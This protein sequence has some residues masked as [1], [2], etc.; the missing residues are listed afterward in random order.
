MLASDF[1]EMLNDKTKL[2]EDKSKEEYETEIDLD[3]NSFLVVEKSEDNV[4]ELDKRNIWAISS[5]HE[6]EEL[7][8]FFE[9]NKCIGLSLL[10]DEN[11]MNFKSIKEINNETKKLD[12][13]PKDKIYETIWQ[14]SRSM[15]KG[16]III[17]KNGLH[18][19][20][21]IGIITSNYLNDNSKENNI[22]PHKRKVKWIIT[23]EIKSKTPFFN[24]DILEKVENKK[25]NII[26][27]F[28]SK[29]N[30]NYR[31]KL[32]SYILDSFKE[33]Y[34]EGEAGKEHLNLFF[35]EKKYTKESFETILKDKELNKEVSNEIWDK[36]I[37]PNKSLYKAYN[38]SKNFF[39]K[40]YELTEE[41]LKEVSYYFFDVLV[42]LNENDEDPET[43]K[44]ILKEFKNS[45]YVKG[46]GVGLL[47]PPLCL[48]NSKY[49][50]IN[51]KT[52]DT[53]KFLNMFFEENLGILKDIEY[54]PE[55]N[56]KI[57]ENLNMLKKIHYIFGDLELFDMFCHWMVDKKLGF[58][59][60]NR[61]IPLIGAKIK[62]ETNIIISPKNKKLNLSPE[63]II[64]KLKLQNN[65]LYR[66]SASLNSGQNIIL[67]GAPGTGK[68]ELAI[69]IAQTAKEKYIND[70]I[71]TTA[72]SD[73]TTFD[74]IGGLM[75]D[76]NGQLTFQEG[77][78]LQAIRENKW[79]IIDEINRSDI[80]KAF[81]Q[82]FTILSGQDVELPFKVDNR[83][84]K[85]ALSDKNDSY[86]DQETNTYWVG[87]NWRILATMNVYDKDYLYDLSYA[88]M[89]RFA[90]IDVDLPNEKDYEK[91][92]DEWCE[93][94]NSKHQ[95]NIKDL[96]E[97]NQYRKIGP[98]IFKDMI[99]YIQA[100]TELENSEN[101]IEECILS[102]ITPQFEGL[103]SKTLEKIRDLLNEK[104]LKSEVID[105]K[106]NEIYG[107][108]L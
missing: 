59:A 104:E 40:N 97:L 73:W 10:P 47:T 66:L 98:A 77:K 87:K 55:C 35:K 84:I 7:K 69:N 106:L 64:T 107:I 1:K 90:F 29:T 62:G 86:F 6:N 75:P 96:L 103:D 32:L 91:L 36:L 2:K 16:D 102:F 58:Y 81:G 8:Q 80:D 44:F 56:I 27:A 51:N 63:E 22:L 39:K 105:A 23:D 12:Y 74:T 11:Y 54:Y 88:F 41:S 33:E 93:N 70:Y 49:F 76:K 19:F 3:Q 79:L 37:S 68:T 9:E 17:A 26:I 38:N 83:P 48:I 92:I 95:E 21:A 42:K 94:L 52:F 4:I 89:R 46:I 24:K 100:R 18:E 101:I 60:K 43:Q 20:S 65:L 57:H 85:I 30:L 78:F 31:D 15:K 67:T 5:K 72:T 71:L 45:K 53:L 82:L 28:Y 99:K 61:A 13:D 14:F 108:G 25:W 34:I 50:I